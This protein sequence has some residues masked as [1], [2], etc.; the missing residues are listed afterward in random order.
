MT[1][2]RKQRRRRR[3]IYIA[4]LTVLA[5]GLVLALGAS[6]AN[7]IGGNFE[8]D[9]NANL[10]V[11]NPAPSIDWVDRSNEIRQADLATGQNDDSY[12]EAPR[13]TT[14]CPDDG[15]ARSRTTSPTCSTSARTSGAGGGGPGLPQPVLEPGERAVRHDPDGLRAEQVRHAPAPTASTR[16]APSATF[17]SS[18][19]STRAARSRRSRP[20]SGTARRGARQAAISRPG[21][22]HDQPRPDPG[23][24]TRTASA[25]R[26]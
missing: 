24:Q 14:A 2:V 16:C 3:P 19:P 1:A 5:A 15:P 22:R 18:T 10:N 20:A 11:D 8:I 12:A 9:A 4:T 7:S 21:D 25:A 6:A 23:G 26:R 17:S 13:K